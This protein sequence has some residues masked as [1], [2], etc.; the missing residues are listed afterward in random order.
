MSS[1][2]VSRASARS[3]PRDHLPARTAQPCFDPVRE[4]SLSPHRSHGGEELG[5]AGPG[6]GSHTND[7]DDGDKAVVEVI[8]RG[9]GR[10]AG[11][12]G[13]QRLRS[14]R[15]ATPGV[16]DRAGSCAARSGASH[17]ESHDAHLVVIR[18]LGDLP[19]HVADGVHESHGRA[20]CFASSAP[21]SGLV[22][23]LSRLDEMSEPSRAIS[24][25][26]RP[27]REPENRHLAK[28]NVFFE[29]P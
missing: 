20:C 1:C 24:G 28:G 25:F 11:K 23:F 22:S 8:L 5:E 6:R 7:D 19:G 12:R 15:V 18:E 14:R 9:N 26:H 10:A 2:H 21:I 4:V 27:G 17:R 13:R 29:E 3:V 16:V